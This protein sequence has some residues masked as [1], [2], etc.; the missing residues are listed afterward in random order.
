MIAE[1]VPN[2][3]SDAS[4]LSNGDTIGSHQEMEGL[5]DQDG[6]AGDSPA[7]MPNMPP[8]I[9][10]QETDAGGPAIEGAWGSQPR[11]GSPFVGYPARAASLARN[12]AQGPTVESSK[13]R[14]PHEIS[15]DVWGIQSRAKTSLEYILA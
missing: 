15:M 1:F 4:G 7:E 10:A 11:C 2:P 6:H 3:E 13:G 14:G 9:L 12:F 5:H 8:T